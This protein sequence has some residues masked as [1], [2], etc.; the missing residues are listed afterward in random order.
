M[1][2]VE[3]VRKPS[4]LAWLCVLMYLRYR[5][6]TCKRVQTLPASVLGRVVH[7]SELGRLFCQPR[8]LLIVQHEIFVV[9]LPRRIQVLAVSRRRCID[10]VQQAL[11]LL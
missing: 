3:F 6:A 9:V 10:D 11:G 5:D 2:L 7:C 8:G 4:L 1:Q